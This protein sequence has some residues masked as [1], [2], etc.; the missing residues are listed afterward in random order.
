MNYTPIQ[1]APVKDAKGNICHWEATTTIGPLPCR[2]VN[3]HERMAVMYL[4]GYIK[5]TTG[6]DAEFSDWKQENS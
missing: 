5:R 3:E 6:K 1:T 4:K 2:V